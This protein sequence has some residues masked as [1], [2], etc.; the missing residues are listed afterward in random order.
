MRG[1][2]LQSLVAVLIDPD[3]KPSEKIQAAKVLGQV[4]EV[5][6]FTERKEITT[7]N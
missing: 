5:A 2:V 7:I 1:L 6:A 4:T 3:S